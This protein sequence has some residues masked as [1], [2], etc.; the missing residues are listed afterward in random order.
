[1]KPIVRLV[2]YIK[3]RNISRKSFEINV[4]LGNGYVKKMLDQDSEISLSKIDKILTA[5]PEINKNWLLTG[6]GNMINEKNIS[7][8]AMD[9]S[10]CPY[11]ELSDRYKSDIDRYLKEIERLSSL[12]DKLTASDP[13]QTKALSA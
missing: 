8:D 5:Y 9:C 6:E 13:S 1:M 10:K 12:V 4:G 3:Y 2:E 11:K 7:S